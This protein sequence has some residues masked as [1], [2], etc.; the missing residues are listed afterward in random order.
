MLRC[1]ETQTGSRAAAAGNSRGPK[2]L[3]LD[4]PAW[5]K[6]AGA[7]I[8][9]RDCGKYSN[10]LSALEQRTNSGRIVCRSAMSI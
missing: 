2:Y 9:R 3:Y 7:A 1:S 6:L 4:L 5:R 10:L 8:G